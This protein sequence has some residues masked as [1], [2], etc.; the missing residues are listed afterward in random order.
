MGIE[1]EVSAD[2]LEVLCISN[3]RLTGIRCSETISES[4]SVLSENSS[5]KKE[6]ND[7]RPNSLP[8]RPLDAADRRLLSILVDDATVSYAELGNKAN[9]SAPAA[10]ERVK[11]LRRSGVIRRTSAMLEPKAVGKSLL[12]FVHVDTQGWGKTPDL[13]EIPKF[14]E[15]EEIHSVAG[16][17]SLL[18]KVRAEDTQGLERI[19]SVIY[20]LPGVVRTRSNIVLST[21]LERPVQA[22]V[23]RES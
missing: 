4:H 21:Y 22:H 15:V 18:L 23:T 9:L 17:A 7:I 10:H 20:G 12:A 6:T 16:D 2:A 13:M 1:A 5:M 8:T 3:Q 11:R 14:P 19:L